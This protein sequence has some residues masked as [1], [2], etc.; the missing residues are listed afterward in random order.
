[1]KSGTIFSTLD[2]A[3]VVQWVRAFAQQLEDWVFESQLRQTKVVK[4]SSDSSDSSTVKRSA[5]G[6]SVTG[7]RRGR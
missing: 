1:M 4:T 5:L 2:A 6:M 7:P 3:A